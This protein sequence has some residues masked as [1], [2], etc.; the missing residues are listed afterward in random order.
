[1][2]PR[3]ISLA[4][5][6]TVNSQKNWTLKIVTVIVINIELFGFTMQ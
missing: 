3:E 1:M 6:C 2:S 5:K 4:W